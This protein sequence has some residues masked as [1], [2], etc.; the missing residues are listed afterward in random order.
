MYL[1]LKYKHR[2][3]LSELLQIFRQEI[4]PFIDNL[5]KFQKDYI[6]KYSIGVYR[7]IPESE[8]KD[9]IDEYDIEVIDKW[10]AVKIFD[11]FSFEHI[12]DFSVKTFPSTI[13]KIKNITG[14]KRA[15][16]HI[17]NGKGTVAEHTDSEYGYQIDPTPV[18][19]Y[20]MGVKIP[21]NN[22]TLVFPKKNDRRP[23][24]ENGYVTFDAN[25]LHSAVND[26]NNPAILLVLHIDR[27]CFEFE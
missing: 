25:Y 11:N 18:Y 7:D 22:L 12:D 26:D 17:V 13:E 16:I 27:E 4:D 9:F 3:F 24:E 1:P 20:V 15:Y 21:N 5:N 14:T 19:N 6:E 2:S 8:Q 23:V 10:F